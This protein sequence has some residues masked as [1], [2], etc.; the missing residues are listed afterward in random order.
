VVVIGGSVVAD[1]ALDREDVLPV[2][3]DFWFVL[4]VEMVRVL[5]CFPLPWSAVPLI[6]L[7]ALLALVVVE[8]TSCSLDR[9]LVG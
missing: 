7:L 1:P 3:P 8:A 6:V 2:I 4:V 9:C 5:L